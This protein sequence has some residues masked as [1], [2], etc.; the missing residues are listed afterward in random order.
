MWI[1][2]IDPWYHRTLKD[3]N[4]ECVRILADFAIRAYQV[5]QEHYMLYINSI[6]Q[7]HYQQYGRQ[8]SFGL[9]D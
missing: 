4:P 9:S 6:Q 1:L 3:K 5:I 8:V 7:N 2:R